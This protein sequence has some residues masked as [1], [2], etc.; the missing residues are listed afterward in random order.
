MIVGFISGMSLAF[1]L[2]A[3][4]VLFIKDIQTGFNLGYGMPSYPY[5]IIYFVSGQKQKIWF[6]V[7]CSSQLKIQEKRME[8]RLTG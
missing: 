4:A 1:V 6:N 2:E 8:Q 7:F 5:V 3:T